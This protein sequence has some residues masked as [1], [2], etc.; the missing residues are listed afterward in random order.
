MEVENR[1]TFHSTNFI[2]HE[3]QQEKVMNSQNLEKWVGF[4]ELYSFEIQSSYSKLGLEFVVDMLFYMLIIEQLWVIFQL[5]IFLG[6]MIMPLENCPFATEIYK[7]KCYK[8]TPSVFTITLTVDDTLNQ[9]ICSNFSP[10]FLKLYSKL[11]ILSDQTSWFTMLLSVK[12]WA[13]QRK[14]G[15]G[16]QRL[17]NEVWVKYDNYPLISS[18]LTERWLMEGKITVDMSNL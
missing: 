16:C 10:T 6:F 5:L 11:Y 8:K 15:R 7:N 14:F 4:I 18:D 9:Q 1:Q 17:K 2:M 12:K 3:A 13:I